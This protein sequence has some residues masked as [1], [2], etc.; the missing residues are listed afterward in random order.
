MWCD[1]TLRFVCSV[2]ALPLLCRFSPWSV[3]KSIIQIRSIADS[4]NV[5][6]R[7]PVNWLSRL[8]LMC[9]ACMEEASQLHHKSQ[10]ALL[11][12]VL[13]LPY[14]RETIYSSVFASLFKSY[15]PGTRLSWF[16]YCSRFFSV[17]WLCPF[18]SVVGRCL[19]QNYYYFTFTS[20]QL[21]SPSTREWD[22]GILTW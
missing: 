8:S 17:S 5:V 1:F 20:K 12:W 14:V 9:T 13:A 15:M 7:F 10:S 6:G 19:S 3:I 11:Y 2:G 18:E 16:L 22:G 4:C 21:V